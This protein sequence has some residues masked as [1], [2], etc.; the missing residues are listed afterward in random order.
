MTPVTRLPDGEQD[1]ALQCSL[2]QGF[3]PPISTACTHAARENGDWFLEWAIGLAIRVVI[4]HSRTMYTNPVNGSMK[5]KPGRRAEEIKRWPARRQSRVASQ[6]L[7][8]Q[9]NVKAAGQWPCTSRSLLLLFAEHG[10]GQWLSSFFLSSPKR[11]W[12]KWPPFFSSFFL[13]SPT[14]DGR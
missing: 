5:M 2:S 11:V 9:Q 10:L 1:G 4:S 13:S 14:N 3:R 12:E 7:Y 8:L 6:P